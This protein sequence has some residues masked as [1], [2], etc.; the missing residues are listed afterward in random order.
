MAKKTMSDILKDAFITETKNTEQEQATGQAATP[1]PAP[2]YRVGV[3]TPPA[4][5]RLVPMETKTKRVQLVLKPSTFERTKAK[6]AA[7]GLSLNE[8]V[9]RLLDAEN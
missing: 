1:E 7:A 3:Y 5:Y 9:S 2:V 8:Y 6:A 4:G